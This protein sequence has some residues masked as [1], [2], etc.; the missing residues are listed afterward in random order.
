MTTM[1]NRML[2]ALLWLTLISQIPTAALAICMQANHTPK[3][4]HS[5][6]D[7]A[8]SQ[9]AVRVIVTLDMAF[10]PEGELPNRAAVNGQRIAIADLQ[11]A[12]INKLH[13]CMAESIRRYK[14]TPTIALETDA[15]GLARLIQA[16]EVSHITED[17]LLPP[18][19]PGSL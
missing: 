16:R 8:H 10:V 19:Q 11:A 9:G 13:S 14:Y 5:L 2:R 18:A 1:L 3:A 7:K 6:I 17:A 12:V 4:P 15:C